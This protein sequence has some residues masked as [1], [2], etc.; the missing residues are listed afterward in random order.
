MDGNELKKEL[1]SNTNVTII[2]KGDTVFLPVSALVG[3]KKGTTL[4]IVMNNGAYILPVSGDLLDP[5]LKRLGV[6][7]DD[8][9][10]KVEIRKVTGADAANVETLAQQLGLTLHSSLTDFQLTAEIK[11]GTTVALNEFGRLYVKRKLPL[12][13][14][15]GPNATVA[16]YDPSSRQLR[17]VPSTF[18]D[19]NATFMRTGNSM[20]VVV[21][22]SRSFADVRGHWGQA[23][24][25]ELASKLILNGTDAGRFEPDRNIT[26]AEFAA[27]IVRTLGLS[28]NT[29]G[30][31]GFSDV[32][33]SAWYADEI[34]TAYQA[35]LIEGY[36]DGTFRPNQ[37]IS[38]EELA[39]LVI[40]ALAFVGMDTSATSADIESL[41]AK[42]DDAV[43]IAWAKAELA[44]AVKLGIIE[45]RT[46]TML[47][48]SANATR[49]EAAIMLKR[50][51]VKSGLPG[52]RIRAI[53]ACIRRPAPGGFVLWYNTCKRKDE[54]RWSNGKIR[55]STAKREKTAAPLTAAGIRLIRRTRM[56]RRKPPLPKLP[57]PSK[58]RRIPET[59]RRQ[60]DPFRD[61]RRPHRRLGLHRLMPTAFRRS[62]RRPIQPVRRSLSLRRPSLSITCTTSPTAAFCPSRRCSSTSC[63]RSCPPTGCATSTKTASPRLS[64][65][66][67][68][69]TSASGSRTSSGAGGCAPTGARSS[70]SC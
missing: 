9:T 60:V 63:A 2:V 12:L 57:Q 52:W 35:G 25:E 43:D 50:L 32:D 64:R 44:K 5:L 19:K 69:R 65:R 48:P 6:K 10:I 22:G 18:D 45:G 7:A 49:A 56:L 28:V 40:R 27:L 31:V 13:R 68:C 39:A 14:K 46:A 66:S 36:E 3:A 61:R 62:H 24:V 4:E 17:F 29:A 53:V 21:E 8:L 41:T 26:R 47:A 23:T 20:Y 16:L 51:L 54:G 38:R 15:P 58:K 34:R 30:E 1:E 11:N 59:C 37:S 67:S 55:V 33:S 70:S 42:F